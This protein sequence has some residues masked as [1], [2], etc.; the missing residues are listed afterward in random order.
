MLGASETTRRG[1]A[2]AAFAGGAAEGASR[3]Q[4]VEAAA[5]ASAT[6]A[7]AAAMRTRSPLR[8]RSTSVSVIRHGRVGRLPE[9]D[10]VELRALQPALDALP[11]PDGDVLGRGDRDDLVDVAV[12]E[13]VDDLLLHDVAQD[14]EVERHPGLGVDGRLDGDL[15]A[16]GVAVE[17][18]ALAVV[19]RQVVRRVEGELLGHAHVGSAGLARSGKRAAII[20]A[21]AGP[22]Q[23]SSSRPAA[24]RRRPAPIRRCAGPYSTLRG[25]WI[26]DMTSSRVGWF[27]STSPR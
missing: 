16:V 17:P 2:A 8:A 15:D 21:R 7:A 13:D 14:R 24:A 11:G 5:A 12:V 26:S 22:G 23:R 6:P 9:L 25:P 1:T 27:F 18:L 4:A 20:A 10:L 3:R 19:V